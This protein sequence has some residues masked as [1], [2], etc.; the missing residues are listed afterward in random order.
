MPRRY[1]TELPD[2]KPCSLPLLS[3]PCSWP[4]HHQSTDGHCLFLTK[5]TAISLETSDHFISV[6]GVAH[7]LYLES[8]WP[9]SALALSHPVPRLDA[10]NLILSSTSFQSISPHYSAPLLFRVSPDLTLTWGLRLS[11]L[12]MMEA[13]R[14]GQNGTGLRTGPEMTIVYGQRNLQEE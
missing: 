12:R 13:W 7:V 5:E 9:S 2:A 14:C 4:L 10:W 8:T 1:T 11:F 3:R 6:K